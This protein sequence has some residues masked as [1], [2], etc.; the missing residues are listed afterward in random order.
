MDKS[1][2]FIISGGGT[3]GHIFP[4]LAIAQGLK[5]R[6][7]ECE[8]LFVGA[9]HKMEMTKVPEAGYR[10]EGL[11]IAGIKR[12]FSL[13]ALNYNF[14]L[15]F[16]IF[17]SLRKVRRIIGDYRPNVVIGVGGY[18]SWATLKVATDLRIPTLI[19]EQNSYPGISNK[20]LA[21]KVSTICVAYPNLERY[22]PAEKIIYTG[23]PVRKDILQLQSIDNNRNKLTVLIVGGSQG[24]LSLNRTIEDNFEY[25]AQ[26]NFEIIWQTGEKFQTQKSAENITILPF[27]KDM[28]AAYQKADIIISRAGALAISELCIIG[29]PTIFVPFPHAAE[30][31]QTKNAEVLMKADAALMIKDEMVKQDLIPALLTL[32]QNPQKQKELGQRI[33]QF[34]KPDAVEHIVNEILK[35]VKKYG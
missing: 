3:G 34:A 12:G 8:I 33:T 5:S 27:I 22:F 13:Q 29:K 17:K 9:E 23:N 32:I 7:P 24:A 2:K 20:R 14:K 28:A 35:L 10:I 15:L 21:G 25:L 19:Q 31:H 30:D 6:L 1:L 4:A 26:Q 18:A 16:K 11:P